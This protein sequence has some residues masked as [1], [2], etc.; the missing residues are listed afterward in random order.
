MATDLRIETENRPGQLASLGEELGKSG[1][2]IQGFCGTVTDGQGIVH[3]LVED[4]GAARASLEAAGFTVAAEREAVVLDVGEDRP[5]YLGEMARRLADNGV[6][7]EGAYVAA[8]TRLVFAVD[9][10]EAARR[11][12]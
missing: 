12:L 1:I 2:N 7:I 4:G 5:G 11:A 9:D 10:A 6:N 3:L 8:G